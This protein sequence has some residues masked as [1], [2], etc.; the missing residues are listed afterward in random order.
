MGGKPIQYPTAHQLARALVMAADAVGERQVLEQYT[1]AIL[2]ARVPNFRCS[3]LVLAAVD[4]AWPRVD[5]PR[6]AKWLGCQAN[7]YSVELGL[8][9]RHAKWWDEQLVVQLMT[10]VAP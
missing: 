4:A 7:I 1:Q 5:L 2:E 8:R 9:R 3:W 10:V 6:M